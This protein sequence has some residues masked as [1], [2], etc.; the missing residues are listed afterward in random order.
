[1]PPFRYTPLV[2]PYVGS[3]AE[4]MGARQ[5]AEAEA[6]EQVG[7]IRAT[8]AQ[9]RGQVLGGAIAGLGKI[10]ASYQDA[11]DRQFQEDQRNRLLAEQAREDAARE[12]YRDIRTAPDVHGLEMVSR[13]GETIETTLPATQGY[14]DTRGGLLMAHTPAETYQTL[15][16]RQGIPTIANP[17]RDISEGG[18]SGIKKWDLMAAEQAFAEAGL[19]EEGREY[20]S[21]LRDSNT[22]MQEHHDE[23]LLEVGKNARRII[24]MG[25]YDLML[26]ATEQMLEK[27]EENGFFSAR[28]IG[29]FR[30]ELDGVTGLPPD[31]R[32]MELKKL[33][34][35]HI[36][37]RDREL[38]RVRSG[39]NLVDPTT[40]EVVVQGQTPTTG[41]STSSQHQYDILMPDGKGGFISFKN[42]TAQYVPGKGE[43]GVVLFSDPRQPG[44]LIDVTSYATL[45]TTAKEPKFV[46]MTHPD[47][48]A[49][50][51]SR[52]VLAV[53][54]SPLHHRLITK[55]Y[56]EGVT[57]TQAQ[58]Q[59]A[60]DLV[61][62]NRRKNEHQF[63]RTQLDALNIIM[64]P[65][66]DGSYKPTEA[67]LYTQGKSGFWSK[68]FVEGTEVQSA[69]SVIDFIVA[70]QILET[71]NRM[72]SQSATGATGFG[73]LS[74]AELLVLQQAST[75][76][77]SSQQKDRAGI[78]EAD[79]VAVVNDLRRIFDKLYRETLPQSDSVEGYSR[80][81]SVLNT[82]VD[83]PEIYR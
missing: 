49:N 2:D 53:E 14:P 39:E 25:N 70:N 52:R 40:G 9:Q 5:R 24:S 60:N 27:Y 36:P 34:A 69:W 16:S 68:A 67:F 62:D 81:S 45:A 12:V 38:Q 43:S 74:E 76:L 77:R 11:R 56:F 83:V 35:G 26:D 6:A 17:Y 8:E 19:G 54:G 32:A 37:D 51:P 20:L 31:Q 63:A 4:L 59:E 3:I 71:I 21:W 1:M 58:Q 7:A 29:A 22:W 48:P 72:K 23:R 79:A 80:P 44:S 82:N 13:P 41:L 30:R 75:R 65:Q 18:I 57:L 61:E 64:P 28:D 10:P 15:P 46:T 50:D 47:L 78:T 33:L 73:Q 55:G 66:I 42:V